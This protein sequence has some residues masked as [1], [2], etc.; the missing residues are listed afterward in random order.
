VPW[1]LTSKRVHDT[2]AGSELVVIE[3]VPHGLVLTHAEQFNQ[4]LLDFLKR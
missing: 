2:I 3:G 4:A 1:E